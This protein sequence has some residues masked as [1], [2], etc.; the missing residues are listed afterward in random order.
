MKIGID[1]RL[2]SQTGVGR[3]IRNLVTE[4]SKI[5]KT[6]EYVLFVRSRDLQGV[7]KQVSNIRRWKIVI[8]DIRWHTVD[9]QLKLPRILNNEELDLMHFPYFSAPV[10]Y[11]KPFVITIHDLII[12]HFPT[13]KASTLPKTFYHMK[14]VG[15]QYVIRRA[16]EK[17]EK[18]I[19]PLNAVKEDLVKTLDVASK[20][21]VVTTEGFDKKILSKRKKYQTPTTRY[22]LYVGNA[23]P[24]KNLE[25][26]IRAF[27]LFRQEGFGDVQLI[28]AGK[29]DYFYKKLEEKIERENYTGI[30]FIHNVTDSDLSYLYQNSQFF[31]SASLMEGF[32]LVALEAMANSSLVVLSDIPSFREVCSDAPVYFDPQSIT[33][34]KDK[35]VSAYKM[36]KMQK[37]NHAEKGIRRTEI[38]SWEKMARQTLQVYENCSRLR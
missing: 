35:M 8:A 34:I 33:D 32:G 4:L 5:D 31:I 3:Y 22:V 18:I 1:C 38:F 7:K 36:S 12:N 21:I 6:N 28:L 19:V 23:Y 11:K 20:K 14:R 27:S 16:V 29:D 24:H 13:G 2:W 17:A 37:N 9:E 25:R 10:F 26:L 30:N 15:Y